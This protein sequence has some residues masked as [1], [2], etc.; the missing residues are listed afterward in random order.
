MKRRIISFLA[1]LVMVISLL[2]VPA[3]A[4]DV[5]E[6]AS[7]EA[8]LQ[9]E[10]PAAQTEEPEET[11]ET[12][13]PDET[14]A[15]TGETE[16]AAPEDPQ[17]EEPGDTQPAEETTAAP[18]TPPEEPENTVP[19]ETLSDLVE[20][21]DAITVN[22]V[23]GT[24]TV[25]MTQAE[26]PFQVNPRYEGIVDASDFDLPEEDPYQVSLMTDYVS[27]SEAAAQVRT[28]MC[29]RIES[30]SV[31]FQS[32]NTDFSSVCHA[33]VDAAL[34]HTGVPTEGD[35]LAW[36][37]GGWSS[38]GSYGYDSSGTYYYTITF[39]VP[40]YTSADQE[41][42]M[43]TQ[44]SALL[45]QLNLSGKSDYEKVK[46]VYDYICANV[47]YDHAN[48]NDDSYTLKYTA[49]A[50]L[51][52]GT[53]VCQGY[54]VL[55]YRL[56][57]ELGVDCRFISG[58]GGG[59]HGWNIVKMGSYYYNADSTW[60][61]GRSSYSYFL[62]CPDN[63][64]D[65]TR[66][67]EYDTEE[68][69]AAY[70]MDTQDY[71]PASEPDPIDPS[72]D[73]TTS[74]TCGENLT[75][76]LY[77]NGLLDITGSGSMTEFDSASAQPWAAARDQIAKVQIAENVTSIGAYAFADCV[78]MT[79][80]SVPNTVD[81]IGEYAF[82]GSGLREIEIPES[83][84]ELADYLFSECTALTFI[85]IPEGVTALGSRVFNGCTGLD[86]AFLA[87]SI[88]TMGT[89][90]F[91]GCTSLEFVAYPD[92][93]TT[94]PDYTFYGCTSLPD[95]SLTGLQILGTGVTAIGSRAF[96]NC[97]ALTAV[98]LGE[99]NLTSIG[100]YA[101]CN[102]TALELITLPA[103][104]KT[105]SSYAFKNCTGLTQV[106]YGSN[107]KGWAAITIGSGNEL[108]TGADISYTYSVIVN[109]VFDMSTLAF[110]ELY[111]NGELRFTG[112][113]TMPNYDSGGSP[114]YDYREQITSIRFDGNVNLGSYAFQDCVNLTEAVI[115]RNATAIGIGAFSNCDSLTSVEIPANIS[116]IGMEAFSGCDALASVVIAEG[117]TTIGNKAFSG[118]GSLA[119][120]QLP[121]SLT[122]LGTYAFEKCTSLTSFTFPAGLTSIGTGT[123]SN[124]TQLCEVVIPDNVTSLGDYAFLYC[125]ALESVTLSNSVTALPT[126]IFQGCISL[127]SITIPTGVTTIGSRAF[128]G[129]GLEQI[130]LPTTLKTIGEEAFWLCTSLQSIHIPE[131]V[132]TISYDAFRGCNSLTTVTIPSTVTTIQNYAFY[133]NSA[134]KTVYYNGT[135]S[136]WSAISIGSNNSSLT[137]AARYYRTASGTCGANLKW[138]LFTDGSL[139]ITGT[140]AMTD[141][142]YNMMDG[143]NVFPGWDNYRNSISTIIIDNGVTTIDDAAFRDCTQLTSVTISDTV[144]TIGAETFLDCPKLSQVKLPGGI[145]AIAARTFSGCT[146]LDG[147]V[148]PSGVTSIGES[149]FEYCA[150]L[151]E[152]ALPENLTDIGAS[153]FSGCS[154]L[155]KIT[156]PDGVTVIADHTFQACAQMNSVDLPAGL[157]SI[158]TQAFWACTGLTSIVIPEGTVSIEDVAFCMCDALQ[159]VTLPGTLTSMGANVFSN[160]TSL[161]RVT[162]PDSLKAL[163]QG[164]FAQCTGLT[165]VTLPETLESIGVAAFYNCRALERLTVPETVTSIGEMVFGECAKLAQIN[166]PVGVTEIAE[167]T[168]Y[169]CDSLTDVYYGGNA[170][171]WAAVII[172]NSN[173]PLLEAVIH[174]TVSDYIG[175][176][177]ENLTW[178]LT[179]DGTLTISGSGDMANYDSYSPT[180][181]WYEFRTSVKSVV[182]NEG[183]TSIGEW[184]FC[185]C[186]NLTSIT[187]PESVTS[188]GCYAFWG[189]GMTG[190]TIPDSVT[191]IGDYAFIDCSSLSSITIPSGVTSIGYGAFSNCSSLVSIILQEGVATIDNMAFF[192]CSSL[193]NINIPDS[194]VDIGE[195]AFSGCSML[196]GIWVSEAN[197]NYSSDAYGVLFDKDKTTL[198]R[199]PEMKNGDYVIPDT[200]TSIGNCAFEDCSN[201]TSITI[202]VGVTSIG[203]YT[204]KYCSN[205]TSIT[206]P[207]GVTSIGIQVFSNCANLTDIILPEGLTRIGASAFEHCYSLTNMILPD[208]LTR[209][210][211]GTFYCC[212]SL[213]SI[214]IPD[215]VT[216]IDHVA[217]HGCTSLT[218]VTIPSGVT[219]IEESTF[220]SCSGLTNIT[221][222][223]SVTSIDNYAFRGC[224][225]LQTITFNGNAPSFG[226]NPFN[227]VSATAYYPANNETWTSD[228][229][230]DYGGTITW[231]PYGGTQED[232]LSI[233]TQP[234]DYVG[235]LNSTASFT[236]AVNK[237]DVT[238]QW[239]FSNDGEVWKPSSSTGYNTDTLTVQIASYRLGQQ[240]RC[241]ITD[242]EGNTVVSD[243]AAMRMP[244]STIQILTQ[245]DDYYGA[246]ADAA[247]FTVEATGEGLTYRWYYST[248][249]ENWSVSYSD[250]YDTPTLT[251]VLRS[252]NSGRMFRCLITDVN[253]NTE[254]TNAVTMA[255][256]SSDITIVTQP[257]SY[258]GAVNDLTEFTVEATGTNLTYQ[259]YFSKDNGA[260]WEM[261]YNEGY[262]TASMKVRLYAYRSGYQ[263][264][265]E[266]SSGSSVKVETDV[267]TIALRAATAVINQHPL[268][269]GGEEGT[270]AIFNVVA[271]GN[272]LSYQWQF[273]KDSG[274]TWGNTYL[275][276]AT[277]Q[278][279]TVEVLAYRDGWQYRCVVTDDSGLSVTTKAATLHVGAAPVIT[280]QPE[281]YTGSVGGTATFTVTAEG[282]NLTYQWQ[283]SNNGGSTWANSGAAGA[284]T[285]SID[286]AAL[287]YRN[288][289]MYRCV[290]SNEYGSV[291]SDA[292]SLTIG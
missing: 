206:I 201:L 161:T 95:V 59:P 163:P 168:F 8:V 49:Y 142:K 63:F 214:T 133:N 261:S 109:G 76:N 19:E 218:S 195:N 257:V 250:G 153:A 68:F 225:G 75:W 12:T 126:G 276:G 34:V 4:E 267:V 196:E 127:K 137:S 99:T 246:E 193:A 25:S 237:E 149:A 7:T 244:P 130:Q 35:Y 32:L 173:E 255:L 270:N 80:I 129:A 242:S 290:V 235:A 6:A 260:T 124:C 52:N 69:H 245:P 134:L 280:G 223:S 211:E 262:D 135:S 18:G 220:S 212:S 65:H 27:E 279:L 157:T 110:W 287:A 22:T 94:I 230:Q 205:L 104:V 275:T 271:T 100:T 288:G 37:Y 162:I 1:A 57:L 11:E 266:I 210:E 281:S 103:S 171:Q 165:E 187:I 64:T 106:E 221:I 85:S 144:K 152:I 179:D 23:N 30:F 40:Y 185:G 188:I 269:A 128:Y 258:T 79:E 207:A 116:T 172:G 113:G 217:F 39:T 24:E 256:A 111:E 115:P 53:A 112:N 89:G 259:W 119:D 178:V 289:Q 33:V 87:D 82:S 17:P 254:W 54:A 114:W 184:T 197:P 66:D 86:S 166:I 136:Q 238:Y 101:F 154:T 202:P 199:F 227:Q 203:D 77:E 26:V 147:I 232:D 247:P 122:I 164:T 143:S 264:K 204:F 190:I 81:T 2:P 61:A 200:V 31:S 176:C 213:T 107:E 70:P 236:V 96:Y 29:G 229:K 272:G 233:T 286:V 228:V 180:A 277:T 278:T 74:G 132:T 194:V 3:L 93:M 284:T 150:G 292:A 92:G 156:I 51:V 131:G 123:L 9:E 139:L 248:G 239:Y 84:T 43:D 224:T 226:E 252:Y 138:N 177:G 98:Y 183:V 208:G 121:A 46:S 83:V 189:C 97:S 240:Y 174:F 73:V 146:V 58:D 91:Y 88:T 10:A 44:V 216:W 263:Y 253:G 102:C 241:E 140:G 215:S 219:S 160:C 117:V 158:G 167:G 90:V 60:D 13:V 41:E 291:I 105:I 285:A 141:F 120:I 273:S 50:A 15:P 249:G 47:T 251:P 28:Y 78:N 42:Q 56:A 283:Y 125:G 231:V 155:Q 72:D 234:V 182:I 71:N 268:D 175:T 159:T 20:A 191:I 192:N 45:S 118:C 48:L 282:A 170:S 265:C 181:P 209:I 198:I 145:T 151:R 14:A 67:A 274:E 169:L 5:E 38:K 108:L 62:V 16:P 222:P 186:N 55:L 148:I 243:A 21:E 36:Q